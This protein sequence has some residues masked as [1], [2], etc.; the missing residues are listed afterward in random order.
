[1][2]KEKKGKRPGRFWASIRFKLLGSY[3]LMVG[4]IVLVGMLSYT[5]SAEAIQHNY[6]EAS[7]QAL[8]MLG[9]YIEFG[10]DTVKGTAVEYLADENVLSYISGSMAEKQAAQT[11][12]YHDKKS[13]LTTRTVADAFI[14]SIYFFPDKAVSLST[15]KRSA[16]RVYSQYTGQEQGAVMLEDVQAYHWVAIPSVIDTIMQVDSGEYAIRLV[17][18]FYRRDA[19]LAIDV[20]SQAIL[21]AL[22]KLSF[23]DGSRTAF[24]SPD[25]VEL[26]QD[27]SRDAVFEGTDF[28]LETAGNGNASGVMED[29]SYEGERYLFMYRKLSDTGASVCALIPNE[30]ITRQ[31]INI[32]YIAVAAVIAA[33]MLALFVGGGLSLSINSSISYIVRKLEK[34]AK[35]DIS[36]RL[37]P[38][39]KDEFAKLAGHMNVM[40]E[41]VDALMSDVKGVGLSVADSAGRVSVSSGSIAKAAGDMSEAMQEMEEGFVRQ[42]RDSSECVGQMGKLAMQIGVVDTETV[43]IRQI[44]DYTQ[45]SVEESL[46]RMTHLKDKANETSAITQ[47][48]IE[49]VAHLGERFA[50]VDTIINTI[51]DI[52]DET[53][54]LALN[55]SIEAARAGDAGRGFAVVAESIKKLAE[56]SIQATNEIRVI[57]D[58]INTEAVHAADIAGKAG[59]VIREQEGA[60][61]ETADTFRQMSGQIS[62]LMDKVEAIVAGVEHMQEAKQGSLDSMENISV[63]TREAAAAVGT[64]AGKT[65]QQ[66]YS[67]SELEKLAEVMADQVKQLEASLQRFSL[68]EEVPDGKRKSGE[69]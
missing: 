35:G 19:F 38:R 44:A 16:D 26:A 25:G 60:V 20:D 2:L 62:M 3:G 30:E 22:N 51:D 59:S 7:M 40:L 27:G 29:V 24:I 33:S 23:G 21:E 4:F 42:A 34:I 61:A 53:T 47:K 1:M 45:S 9:E 67:V 48:I 31:V 28:Y 68:K 41:S 58:A 46:D 37:K 36:I 63:V 15:N 17:K 66:V 43:Q 5:A 69:R 11:T 50:S 32:K 14:R 39:R 65:N 49:C 55:A 13:E 8:N 18:P 54:L 57:V 56:Q 52:S 12:W 10:F 64:I 6:K